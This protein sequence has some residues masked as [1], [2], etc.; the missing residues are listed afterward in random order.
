MDKRIADTLLR[1][2]IIIKVNQASEH[3]VWTPQLN[4]GVKEID[5]DHK[6]LE[7]N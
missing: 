6:Y 2:V 5:N 1:T 7:S 3:Y 4:I